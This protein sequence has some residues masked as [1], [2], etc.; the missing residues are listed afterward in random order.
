MIDFLKDIQFDNEWAWYLMLIPILMSI[1]FWFMQ[2]KSFKP[3]TI[4]TLSGLNSN[5]HSKKLFLKKYLPILPILASV[6]II[7]C[8]A[9]PR[10]STEGISIVLS[11]DISGSMAAEDL[12]PNRLEAAL[13]VA[14]KFIQSR[15]KDRIGLVVFKAEAFTQ[16]PITTDHD[17]LL[18]QLSKL[19][20]NV[21][22][23]GTAIGLGLGTAVARLKESKSK[24]KVII[25]LTD[26]VNN[27]GFLDPTVAADLA[28]DESIRV[29]TIAVGRKDY[30]MQNYD[31]LTGQTYTVKSEFDE[32]LLKNISKKTNG[33]F[34]NASDNFKMEEIFKDID[35]MEKNII[36]DDQFSKKNELFSPFALVAILLLLVYFI[37]QYSYLKSIS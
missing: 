23:D 33:K 36:L 13:S 16:C 27:A 34:Y 20:L 3:Y 5:N 37:L 35:L 14:E 17:A 28:S 4:S 15:P 8:I 26:G 29:Y 30:P 11:L 18:E 2:K 24:S 9:R 6:F 32:E 1:W 12:Y 31:P 21:L 7:I 25:L 22:S 10:G 19:Q